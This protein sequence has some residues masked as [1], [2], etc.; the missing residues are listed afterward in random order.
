MLAVDYLPSVADMLVR[1]PD[2][3]TADYFHVVS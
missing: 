3:T 2:D 1:L